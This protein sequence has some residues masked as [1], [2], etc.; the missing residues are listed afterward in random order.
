MGYRSA[1]AIAFGM[2]TLLVTCSPGGADRHRDRGI[3][4]AVT[5]G[6][7]LDVPRTDAT[8][9]AAG[10]FYAYLPASARGTWFEAYV[11]VACTN[12]TTDAK[13]NC[14]QACGKANPERISISRPSQKTLHFIWQ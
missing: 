5:Q 3:G 2:I 7:A 14:I 6:S 13:W 4:F 11:S 1:T 10:Q 12:N 8:T 9:D